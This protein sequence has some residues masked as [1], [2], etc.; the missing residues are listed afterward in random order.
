MHYRNFTTEDTQEL[1][2]I[3]QNNPD[4]SYWCGF[5]QPEN[6]E[7]CK[8][9]INNISKYKYWKAIIK[10]NKIIGCI[11]L[12]PHKDGVELGYWLDNN[13]RHQNIIQT[14]IKHFINIA[15]NEIGTDKIYCGWFEGNEA[16]KRVQLSL[17]FK[18]IGYEIINVLGKNRKEYITVC[19]KQDTKTHLQ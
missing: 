9:Y 5:S 17:G 7:Q 1:Y 6:L 13:Y 2:T 4:I 16:S 10:D 8:Q 3:L 19:H 15:F 11:S 14:A 12:I 18:E